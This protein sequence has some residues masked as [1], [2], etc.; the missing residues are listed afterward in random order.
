MEDG[1]IEGVRTPKP[2]NRL[3]QNLAW[4]ITSAIWPNTPKFKPIAPV[5]AS[6][7]IGEISLSRGFY[8]FF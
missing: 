8:K 2:L 1:K 7:Q 5:G 3:P 4:M 6:Q